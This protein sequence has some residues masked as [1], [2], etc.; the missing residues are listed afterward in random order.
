[1]LRLRDAEFRVAASLAALDR[2]PNGILLFNTDGEVTFANQA[3]SR[4]L[5][6]EDGLRLHNPHGAKAQSTLLASN[7][8]NQALLNDA[9]REALNADIYSARHFSHTISIARPSGKAPFT[10]HFSSLSGHNE[11]GL[12]D[13]TPRAIAFLADSAS[14]LQLNVELLKSTYGLTASEIR[15]AERVANGDS[16][17]EAARELNVSINTIKTQLAQL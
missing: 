14:L 7:Q 6:Q 11:F 13:E 10:F 4:I 15:A 17:E 5:T 9:I 16:V 1:M 3:A 12:S 8:Q 2:L